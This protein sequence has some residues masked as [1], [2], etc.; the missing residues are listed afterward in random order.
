MSLDLLTCPTGCDSSLAVVKF[1]PCAAELLEAEVTY[2]YI[3]ND[4]F[5]L[6][7]WEDIM[8]WDTRV[9]NESLDDD[10]IRELAVIGALPIPEQ[11]EKPISQN[12]TAYSQK[13]FTLPFI[14]DDNSDEN[15]DFMRSTGCNRSYRFWF[16][17]AGGKLYGGNTGILAILKGNEN[18]VN[19][20]EEFAV[21]EFELKWKSRLAPIRIDNPMADAA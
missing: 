16:A 21:L 1:S 3:A 10:A 7:N 13:V 2:V 15:Y 19:T 14:I 4:G 11:T 9:D 20:R 17:T 5:P 18:I 8:E 6:V 12:R